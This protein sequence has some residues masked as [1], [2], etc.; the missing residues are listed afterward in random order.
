MNI[1]LGTL[2]FRSGLAAAVGI[3]ACLLA[4]AFLEA[5]EI[6]RIEGRVVDSAGQPISGVTATLEDADGR[7]SAAALSDAAGAYA[8]EPVASGTYTVRLQL[9]ERLATETGVEVTEGVSRRETEVAWQVHFAETITVQ[10]PSLRSQRMVEAPVAVTFLGTQEIARQAVHN[11][12]PRLLA[13][14]AGAEVVQSDICDFSLNSRGYNTDTSRRVL[15]LI[16]G[17]DPSLPGIGSE[18]WSALSFPLDDLE[19]V[20]LVRGP[21]SALYGAGAFNGVLDLTTRPPRTSQGFELRLSGGELATGQAD[22]RWAGAVGSGTFLKLIAGYREGDD[23]T[24]SRVGEG[25]YAGL[26]NEV[27]SPPEDGY[28]IASGSLRVDRTFGGD[29]RLLT[30]E[31]GTSRSTGTVTIA[32]TGR[33]QID[34]NQR[35]WARAQLDAGRWQALAFLTAQDSDDILALGTGL[36]LYL[37][38]WRAGVDLSAR[39]G[40]AGGR[41]SAVAGASWREENLDSADPQGVQGIFTKARSGDRSA[42]FGQVDVD[43]GKRI[44]GTV[45]VRVDQSSLYATKVSPRAGLVFAPS[46]RHTVR[47]SY[48]EAFQSPSFVELFLETAVAPPID[49]GPL[50]EALAPLLGGIPLGFS[51]IPVLAVGNADLEVER[52]RGFELGYRGLFGRGLFLDATVYANRLDNFTTSLLPQLGTPLGRLNPAYGPY[53]P[54]AGLSPEAVTVVLATL[55]A[56]LPPEFLATLSNR[57]DGSPVFVPV[58]ITNHGA[59]DTAGLELGLTYAWSRRWT[60]DLSATY[61]DFDVDASAFAGS[62]LPNTPQRRASASVTYVGDRFDATTKVRWVDD[63]DWASGFFVG[64]VPAYDVVDLAV[65]VPL[66]DHWRL[67]VDVSNLLDDVHYETFGGSLLERRALAHVTY[68]W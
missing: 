22:L 47:L 53:Q 64:P 1:G 51:N 7:T 39:F 5:R 66:G 29:T 12:L 48:G 36:P 67:G 27:V 33:S 11:Q 44:E 26:P 37:D 61:F 54:P 57:A 8:F 68:G 20:E 63:F 34:D 23:F 58:S 13:G 15:T 32:G 24:V 18:D 49:L 40:F 43:L 17:R 28:S 3:A 60:L 16:D 59:A 46:P 35:P 2:D 38:T 55:Q 6:G 4:P 10:A 62:L 42:A 30:L 25:E 50:E 65:N 31:A 9:G 56:V 21:G 41:G 14:T 52:V 19:S 45:S